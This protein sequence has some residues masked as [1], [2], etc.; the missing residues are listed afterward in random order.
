MN[1]VALYRE[2]LRIRRFEESILDL[3]SQ[4]KLFGTTHAYIGQEAI[5]VG[6]L[7]HLE[8]EDQVVSNHRCHGHYL[9][10]RRNMSALLAELMGKETGLCSGRGGSQHLYDRGFFTNGVQGGT[11]ALAVGLGL[12]QRWRK[13][14]I[15]VVFLGDGTLGEGQTY[16][17]FNMASLWKVPV[18]FVIENNFYSQSTPSRLQIAGAIEARPRA[19][20]IETHVCDS[21]LVSETYQLAGQAI[22]RVRQSGQP[23]ALVFNTFRLCSHSKSDDG[24]P[25]SVIEP[26]RAKDPLRLASQKLDQESLKEVEREVEAEVE[27]ALKEA[28]EAAL[29]SQAVLPPLP[30]PPRWEP[31]SRQPARLAELLHQSLSRLLEEDPEVLLMGQDLLAPYGGAFKITRDLS[32]RFPDRVLATPLSE[33]G[34]TGVAAGLALAGLKPILEIMFGD[35]LTLCVDPLVNYVSKFREMYDDQVRCPLVVRTPMGGR[36]GY[37]PTHSQSLERLLLG[38]PELRMVALSP[39]HH[40]DQLLT[41]AVEDQAP[42]LFVENKLLYTRMLKGPDEQGWLGNFRWRQSL[43]AYPDVTLSLVDFAPAEATL[44]TYGGMTEQVLEA[45]ETLLVEHEI[46]TEVVVVSCLQ[47]LELESVKE[48]LSRCGGRLVTVEE[49]PRQA[50]WGAEAIASCCEAGWLK[51]A[52]RVGSPLVSIPS[53]RHLEDQ[54][55][56]S[57]ETILAAVRDLV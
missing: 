49:G 56:P 51:Q 34:M 3:F 27:A 11:V 53:A 48:S 29:A 52:A 6:V 54:V 20:D 42:V 1:L 23:Q 43:S 37:G 33:T 28:D 35:F 31:P 15:V 39:L 13:T 38:I 26:W 47:P 18:L 32:Q 36:R 46:A 16:E 14:G 8:A 40:P 21:H 10:A 55:L 24:R 25:E 5:A 17:A 30:L 4:G 19:F 2:M 22:A 50:G 12:A 57:V 41:S 45:A 7:S 44:L 9:V